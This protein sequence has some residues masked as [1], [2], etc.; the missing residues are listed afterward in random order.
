[1]ATDGIGDE[2]PAT[3]GSAVISRS[4]ASQQQ[5]PTTAEA[6]A[7]SQGK[8][9]NAITGIG[10]ATDRSAA[11]PAVRVPGQDLGPKCPIRP[12]RCH[13]ARDAQRLK[14][15]KRVFTGLAGVDFIGR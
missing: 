1:M 9:G 10:R 5:C 15:V 4:C 11:V 12:R 14:E 3:H 13:G 7:D 6:S 2:M 8:R